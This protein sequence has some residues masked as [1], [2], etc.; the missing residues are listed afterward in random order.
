MDRRSFAATAMATAAAS[1]QAA[2][3]LA[4]DG[5]KPVREKMLAPH[6]YGPEYYG[7]E[8]RRE[9]TEVVETR[10]PFRW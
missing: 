2:P 7:E 6:F 1:V 3:Q 9:L 4:I 8:E 10:R 5:G